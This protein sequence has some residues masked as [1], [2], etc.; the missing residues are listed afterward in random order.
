[1][2]AG[3]WC[4][5]GTYTFDPALLELR[6]H[7]TPVRLQDK[8]ALL[9]ARL[10]E[11]PGA[12][13]TR[14]ELYRHLWPDGT[15]VEFDAG[16]NSAVRRLREVLDDSAETPRYVETMARR[17]YR[18]VAPAEWL[19]P[20][21]EAPPPEPEP[22]R[23]PA[24]A[25]RWEAPLLVLAVLALVAAVVALSRRSAQPPPDPQRV[26]IAVLPFTELSGDPEQQYFADGL[27]EEMIAQLGQ[28]EPAR[29]G[30][31]AP[32]SVMRYRGARRSLR[33]VGR[34]LGVAHVIEGSVQRLEGRVRVAARLVDVETETQRWSTTY[35]RAMEDVPALQADLARAVAQEVQAP[36]S[37]EGEAR[38]SSAPPLDPQAYDAYLK[39]RHFWA[40]RTPQDLER[41][42]TF[43]R[44]ALER[45]PGYASAHA[46]V[47]EAFVYRGWYGFEAPSAAFPQAR[48][49]AEAALANDPAHAGARAAL[50]A[51]RMLYDW[52]LAAGQRDFRQAIEANPSDATV[53]HWYGFSL[54]SEGRYDAALAQIREGQTLDPRSPGVAAGLAY[55]LLSARRYPEAVQECRASLRLDPGHLPAYKI[56]GWTYEEQGRHEDALRTYDEGESATGV[57]LDADRARTLALAGRAQQARQV[58]ARVEAAARERYVPASYLA[59]VHIALGDSEAALA[60]LEKALADRAPELVHPRLAV[61]FAPLA[62][63]PRFQAL[64]RRTGR[65]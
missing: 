47:A 36:R 19:E 61:E 49:A 26:L 4:R 38:R 10:L 64:R 13:V 52:D 62:R 54:A 46:G 28:V 57:R 6:R 30:V 3:R 31:I 1:M 53:R 2:P 44:L 15:Y 40:R 23:P 8:P 34:E 7:G 21:P 25:V 51:T 63:D 17:G 58:L 35:E 56:L 18:F 22:P 45:A 24:R 12:L 20:A 42:L 50:G 48:A 16:L 65:E 14:E 41:A 27:T 5:F 60:L 32:G 33:E 39:G 59:R 43:F 37:A 29:L 55:A 9:L 11:Q